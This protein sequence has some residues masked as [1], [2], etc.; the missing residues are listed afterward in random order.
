M[1][2]QIAVATNS[3]GK[4]AAGHSILRKLEAASHH[5]FEGVEVAMECL[6]AHASSAFGSLPTRPAR[7]R[8]AAADVRK[9]ADTLGLQ[10][11]VLQPFGAYDG[12]K[13][14]AMVEE[15]LVE[16]ELWF[17][18]CAILRVSIFQITS[19]LYPLDPASLSPN[20]DSLASNMRRLG[21]LAQKRG[22]RV[23]YEAPAWGI[24]LDTWQQIDEVLRKVDLENV[25]HCLDTFHI[26]ARVAGDPLNKQHPVRP[27]GM[28]A[29]QQ[30]LKEMKNTL[31]PQHIAYLQLSDAN[32]A[33]A[34]QPGYPR[35]D[36]AQPAYMTQSRN[37]RVY[38]GEGTLP[39]FEVAKAVFDLGYSGWVSME[40]FHT[41]HW[42]ARPS[43]P[44][45][46]ARR[47]MASWR[48]VREYCGLN[49]TG[50]NKGSKGSRL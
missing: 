21:L 10:L 30:S 49:K 46:W 28:A 42:D 33:D 15:R 35:R 41:D 8:A 4:S 7:L 2:I 19:A 12:L 47:G 5:G 34:D 23:G 39:V 20:V 24:H 37:R 1:P 27:G 18:L 38:P 3:L 36:P 22:L 48:R 11:V 26:A 16:A 44:D 25:Q 29:L 45:E 9:K 14:A 31:L 17:D 43:V 40:V 32:A 13:D 6:E 50:G